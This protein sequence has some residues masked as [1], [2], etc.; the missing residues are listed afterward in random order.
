MGVPLSRAC[1][2][3]CP[4]HQ[5]VPSHDAE[6]ASLLFVVV[7]EKRKF[8]I[9]NRTYRKSYTKVATLHR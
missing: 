9:K 4:A 6:I 5:Q 7:S 8:I 2:L 1:A 3:N